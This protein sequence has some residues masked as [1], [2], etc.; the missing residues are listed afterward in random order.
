MDEV[1]MRKRNMKLFPIYRQLGWDYIFFYT[2]NFLFLTQVKNINP[3]D[4]VLID[5]FYYLFSTIAQ[6]P[7][8]FIVEFLGRKNSIVLGSILNCLYIVVIIF[9]RNLFDLILAELISS[10]AFAIKG[11]AD[12]S[13][14]N[15][16]IP[17]TKNKSTIFAKINEKGN[18][19]YYIINSVSTIIAGILYEVNPYI[20]HILSFSVLVLATIVSIGF[21][22]PVKS[23]R[24]I[25]KTSTIKQLRD[26]FKFVLKSERIKSLIVFSCIMTSILGILGTYEVTLLEDLNIS[27]SVIGFIFALLGIISG[28]STKKQDEFHQKYRNKTLTV[29]GVSIAVMCII[30]G[31]AGVLAKNVKA[32]IFIILCAFVVKYICSSIYYTLID[33]YLTNFS[34]DKIDTKIFLANNFFRSIIS[35]FFGI[36]ASFLLNRLNIA[37]SMIIVGMVFFIL[38]VIALKYM[39]TRL[40]LK[41]EEYSKEELKY[42]K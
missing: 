14:L 19:N 11:C 17:P 2:I 5:S 29:L 28:I 9:S 31:L 42:D 20:P 4:V 40:G 13:L 37:Y 39:E 6:I 22:E 7:S 36:L 1:Q 25:D 8:T 34:N 41:P 15:E 32:V 35:A 38:I 24:K 23:N 12:P 16:S 21:I 26:A 18:A 27:P 33:K 10:I 30:S 3:A